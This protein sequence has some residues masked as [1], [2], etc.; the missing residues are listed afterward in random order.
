MADIVLD[1]I[2]NISF[3]DLTNTFLVLLVID[4]S[5]A[6]HLI[7]NDQ[8]YM[9]YLFIVLYGIK[10]IIT[11]STILYSTSKGAIAT[12]WKISPLVFLLPIISIISLINIFVTLTTLF[13]GKFI[14]GVLLIMM[15]SLMSIAFIIM[16]VYWFYYSVLEYNKFYSYSITQCIKLC[17]NNMCVK[18]H[19]GLRTF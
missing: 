14:F 12:Q 3:L 10:M 5:G 7:L 8:Y 15:R 2:S 1:K 19:S 6:L 16:L 17:V 11:T 13:P 4:V 9:A 18:A